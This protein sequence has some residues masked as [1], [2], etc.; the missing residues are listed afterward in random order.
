MDSKRNILTA[1]AHSGQNSFIVK[2]SDNLRLDKKSIASICQTSDGLVLVKKANKEWRLKFYNADGS[3][4]NI[5]FNGTFCAAEFLRTYLGISDQLLFS[6]SI[7]II[8]AVLDKTIKLH[9]NFK[10]PAILKLKFNEKPEWDFFFLKMIDRH[11]VVCTSKNYIVK[12]D[13]LKEAKKLRCNKRFSPHGTN[14]HF[15]FVK[16]EEV[17]IRHYEKGIERETLSCG[18][19]CLAAG[20]VLGKKVLEFTSPGGKLRLEHVDKDCWIMYG[21]P[22]IIN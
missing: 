14:I 17:F 22:E 1:K 18:S 3:Q 5:S 4:F 7:G 21:S 13:F 2:M 15:V 16:N 6:T 9:F 11:L 10:A 12:K 20:I 8:K 19:G